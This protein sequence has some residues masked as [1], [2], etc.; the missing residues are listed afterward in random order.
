LGLCNARSFLNKWDGINDY[1]LDN[2]FDIFA[3]TE[4][5]ISPDKVNDHI[6][7]DLLPG[8]TL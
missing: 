5:W 7:R 1:I 8:Y 4:T 6:L 2:D 3:I